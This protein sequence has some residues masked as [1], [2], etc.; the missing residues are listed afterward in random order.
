MSNDFLLR[1]PPK[2]PQGRL[3][4]PRLPHVGASRRSRPYGWK[5]DLWL[6]WQLLIKDKKDWTVSSTP[7]DQVP[8]RLDPPRGVPGRRAKPS[9]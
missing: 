4:R 6:L 3:C 8:S 7:D 1:E 5:N 9:P 2:R